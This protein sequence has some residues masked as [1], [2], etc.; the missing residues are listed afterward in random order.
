MSH[1]DI[2]PPWE[3]YDC[4]IGHNDLCPKKW[5]NKYINHQI[6]CLCKCHK[7]DKKGLLKNGK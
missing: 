7:L 3:V 2:L 4:P 5:R 1:F 6:L